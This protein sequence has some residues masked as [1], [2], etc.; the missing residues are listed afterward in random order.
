[1]QS[2]VKNMWPKLKRM[3]LKEQLQY[4][5]EVH[6]INFADIE[7]DFLFLDKLL[8]TTNLIYTKTDDAFSIREAGT[9]DRYIVMAVLADS[10]IDS[11]SALLKSYRKYKSTKFGK[12]MCTGD[13]NQVH[14]RYI[15]YYS[16]LYYDLSLCELEDGSGYSLSILIEVMIP[17]VGQSYIEALLKFNKG[18]FSGYQRLIRQAIPYIEKIQNDKIKLEDDLIY[19]D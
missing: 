8:A 10:D 7:N 17:K 12:M 9:I 11:L 1:M 6:N 2:I 18:L 15:S 5:Y 3:L 19:L 14:I 13:D 16:M 4:V